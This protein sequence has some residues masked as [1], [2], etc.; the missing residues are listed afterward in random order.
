MVLD[1]RAQLDFFQRDDLL[2]LF[3]FLIPFLLLEPE[4]AKIHDPTGGWLGVRRNFNQVQ[5]LFRRQL[6]GVTQTHDTQLLVIGA[7]YTHFFS[8]NFLIDPQRFFTNCL[9]PLSFFSTKKRMDRSIRHW[10]QNI[11]PG[12]LV[13]TTLPTACAS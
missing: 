12:C 6:E 7:D 3:G 1:I 11:T 5:L 8:P 2:F 13:L 4:F 9:S 10:Q